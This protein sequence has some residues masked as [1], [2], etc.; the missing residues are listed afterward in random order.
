MRIG[1]KLAYTSECDDDS[2][3]LDFKKR[4]PRFLPL[5]NT[6][7]QG[8]LVLLF[9]QSHFILLVNL[10]SNFLSQT[11]NETHVI[12]VTVFVHFTLKFVRILSSIRV[13]RRTQTKDS[14]PS[15]LDTK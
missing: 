8:Q 2:S 6:L 9:V 11:S 7:S 3:L 1:L 5:R 15:C 4:K 14:S 10:P 12:L 13:A